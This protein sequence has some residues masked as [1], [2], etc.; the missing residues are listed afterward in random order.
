MFY[1]SSA[2]SSCGGYRSRFKKSLLLARPDIKQSYLES[3]RIQLTKRADYPSSRNSILSLLYCKTYFFYIFGHPK[4]IFSALFSLIL[5]VAK[6]V[7][8]LM[9]YLQQHL[10]YHTKSSEGWLPPNPI[11]GSGPECKLILQ[12]NLPH[13][14][15]RRLIPFKPDSRV[16]VAT[17][18]LIPLE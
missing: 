8:N 4:L 3:S 2:F 17:E 15:F 18:L 13:Q 5:Y 7:P 12:Q 1:L 10:L 6:T 16:C 14:I 9:T 11:A